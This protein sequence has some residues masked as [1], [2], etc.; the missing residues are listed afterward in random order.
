MP[1]FSY[2]PPSE[3]HYVRISQ[4]GFRTYIAQEIKFPD[5]GRNGYLMIPLNEISTWN[6]KLMARYMSLVNQDL[7]SNIGNIYYC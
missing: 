1:L 5:H 2:E 7:D 6:K 3:L 4:L